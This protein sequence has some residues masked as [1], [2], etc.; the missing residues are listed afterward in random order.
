MN[1]I[2][3]TDDEMREVRGL[4][5]DLGVSSPDLAALYTVPLAAVERALRVAAAPSGDVVDVPAAVPDPA[6]VEAVIKWLAARG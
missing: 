1:P 4:R 5:A 3:L 2:D 6:A